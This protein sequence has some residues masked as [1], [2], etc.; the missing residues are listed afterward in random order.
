M[1]RFHSLCPALA[2]AFLLFVPP[3]FAAFNDNGDG[4][5]TDDVTGLIWDKCSWGQSNDT[6]CSTGSAS[7]HT[8][9]D[10]LGVAVTANAANYKGFN[11]WRLPNRTELESLVDITKA[12]DPTI[13]V[14]AFPNTPSSWY[15]TS[16]TYAPGPAN[17][18]R[19]LF[20]SGYT[21]AG[22]K[23]VTSRVRLVRSGQS[24]GAFDDQAQA[25]DDPDPAAIPTLAEWTLLMLA[26][27]LALIGFGWLRRPFPHRDA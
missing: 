23:S 9:A 17:A 15:W 8:W 27:L 18:W 2:L 19:V 7:T 26:G 3:A 1:T 10:A 24:F 11:D 4:T 6:D 16:T 12:T 21:S 25:Q 5:V 14:T 13:D 22:G 20:D